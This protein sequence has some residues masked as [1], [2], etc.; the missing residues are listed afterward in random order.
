MN[1]SKD[2]R[3]KIIE[4]RRK[5]LEIQNEILNK[6]TPELERFCDFLGNIISKYI[7]EIELNDV[8][9]VNENNDKEF[10]NVDRMEVI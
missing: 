4:K 2:W 5:L 8:N 1:F 10:L 6:S 9:L 3:K 7:H